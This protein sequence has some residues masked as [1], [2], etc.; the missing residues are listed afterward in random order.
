MGSDPFVVVVV[1][2]VVVVV[3][4]VVDVLLDMF[5]LHSTL[6]V[7]AL[8]GFC[9]KFTCSCLVHTICS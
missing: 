5:L 3:G 2:C 9:P 4:V 6:R 7:L 8:P 1:V